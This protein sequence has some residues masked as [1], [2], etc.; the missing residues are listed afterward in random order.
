MTEPMN[1]EQRLATL[2][3]LAARVP[4]IDSSY[5]LEQPEF[6][7]PAAEESIAALEALLPAALPPGYRACLRA[8]GGFIAMDVWNG[9]QLFAPELVLRMRGEVAVPTAIPLDGVAHPCIAVAGDGGGNLFL[10]TLPSGPVFK[11]LHETGRTV[12]VADSFGAFLDRVALDWEHFIEG[13]GDW[14]YLSG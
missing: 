5:E 7:A 10:L 8:C 1:S 6:L 3:A 2:V 14:R 11:W 9:Y 4:N 12:Q 13:D